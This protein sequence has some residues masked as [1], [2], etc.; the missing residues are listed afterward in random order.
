MPDNV[1][2]AVEE[3]L[4][5]LGFNVSSVAEGDDKSPDLV[6]WRGE[7]RYVV[8]V[9]TKEDDAQRGQLLA[10]ATD[11]GELFEEH[12]PMGRRNRISGIIGS[13]VRQ[14]AA[15]ATDDPLRLLWFMSFGRRAHVY[16]SQVRG[17]LLGTTRVLDLQ[18]TSWQ[19]E[20][21][22]FYHSDFYRWRDLL[23]GAVI[24]GATSGQLCINPF[25]PRADRLRRS[26]LAVAFGPGVLDPA[27]LDAADEICTVDG[28]VDRTDQGAVLKHLQA[29][30]S[31]PML[32]NIDIGYHGVWAGAKLE[33][34]DDSEPSEHGA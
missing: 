25:S 17:T 24:A 33:D 20:C 1:A 2:R 23:D 30:Y 16:Q 8:E 19:R 29:K 26:A 9:K 5:H 18:D 28:S 4:R 15:L 12:M 27:A 7:E 11:K 31:R 34:L 32:M 22:F 10:E 13:G 14:L 6:V 21:Y 3:L